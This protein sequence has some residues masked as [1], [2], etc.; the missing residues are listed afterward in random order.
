MKIISSLLSFL[1]MLIFVFSRFASVWQNS[2]QTFAPFEMV[3]TIFFAQFYC[4]TVEHLGCLYIV[5]FFHRSY[6]KHFHQFSLGK[7]CWN[8]IDIFLRT[9]YITSKMNKFKI[10]FSFL[11]SHTFSGYVK[12]HSFSLKIDFHKAK[13]KKK[14]NKSFRTW[15]WIL[16]SIDHIF[17]KWFWIFKFS[18]QH[19]FML[20]FCLL[21]P[22]PFHVESK[23]NS[24]H[25]TESSFGAEI[26]FYFS[27]FNMNNERIDDLTLLKCMRTRNT[28][29]QKQ[30]QHQTVQT[31]QK[32]TE[33][34]FNRNR[35]Q[36]V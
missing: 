30:I 18:H 25:W 13:W 34:I 9:H 16:K 23:G 35:W 7:V 15:N 33:N 32:S 5:N 8:F 17:M 14:I 22:H 21:F 12:R 4:T 36:T 2:S 19:S 20:F 29:W 31:N 3:S 1:S 27:L 24:P 10:I 26:T 11:L 28:E 6:E